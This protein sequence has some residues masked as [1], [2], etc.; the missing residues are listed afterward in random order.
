VQTSKKETLVQYSVQKTD[1]AFGLN[2][3]FNTLRVDLLVRSN[4][5]L[6]RGKTS[7]G[8]FFNS[9]S[10]FSAPLVLNLLN[11]V[12]DRHQSLKSKLL[13]YLVGVA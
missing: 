10:V 6:F 11:L 12:L 5:P 7:R 1:R 8:A 3:T 4:I 13:G 9:L 2:Q